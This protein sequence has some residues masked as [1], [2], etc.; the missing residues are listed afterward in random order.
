MPLRISMGNLSME[1]VSRLSFPT[2]TLVLAPAMTETDVEVVRTMTGI[3]EAGKY[4]YCYFCVKMDKR[5]F[6]VF[7][8]FLMGDSG[9]QT[10]G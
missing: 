1:P 5:W 3:I 7:A 6:V 4:I 8:E 9:E 2:L 10:F